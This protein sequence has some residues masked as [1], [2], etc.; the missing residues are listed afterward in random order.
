MDD[1]SAEISAKIYEMLAS[2]SPLERLQMGCSMIDT[3]KH[4]ITCGILKDHPHISKKNLRR[5]IFL[6]FYGS[7]FDPDEREKIIKHLIQH[8]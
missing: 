1:T 3:S 7:D 8:T 4:L 5:E 2:K 6:R